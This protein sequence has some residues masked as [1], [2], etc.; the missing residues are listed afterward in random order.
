MWIA[1]FFNFEVPELVLRDP[2]LAKKDLDKCHAAVDA[3]FAKLEQ[4]CLDSNASDGDRHRASAVLDRL[5]NI[6]GD[7][8]NAAFR[9]PAVE[10]R[11]AAAAATELLQGCL[12]LRLP[13]SGSGEPVEGRHPI[14]GVH[15]LTCTHSF[16]VA[17]LW[18]C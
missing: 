17:V 1:K 11:K 16:I 5:I 12:S 7:G 8:D 10:V 6:S 4:Q 9:P 2:L 13:P 15:S 3:Q 14:A 18:C